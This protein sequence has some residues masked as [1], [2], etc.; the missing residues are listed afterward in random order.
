MFVYGGPGNNTVN[1]AWSWMN[2]FWFQYLV[3]QGFVVISVDNRGTGYRGRDFKHATYL[4]LGKLET[5]DQISAAIHMGKLNYINKDKIGIFGWSYGGYMSSLC[6][7]KG[8]DIF[9]SA[10]AVAPV[11]NWRYYDNIY[12]E[13]FMRTPNEN[14]EN[15]DVNS[16]I[17]HVN[18]IKG[19]YL[20]I[21]GTADDNVHF[22]NSM[23][24]VSSLVKSNIEFDFF[25]Y[26]N[27]NHGIYGGYTRLHLYN[28]MTNFLIDNL[29]E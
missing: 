7:S 3:K 10:I 11:T 1:N 4:Q 13:R 21:H 5:E 14:G 12:T 2:Y 24:M 19:N 17:N 25:A 9:N 26:P 22:Q 29:T 15:Y 27:K 20:L 16:P 8:A 18:K 28:K 23:E 6:I